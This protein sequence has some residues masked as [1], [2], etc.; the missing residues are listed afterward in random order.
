MRASI[1]TGP[2]ECMRQPLLRVPAIPL[3]CAALIFG[4]LGAGCGE[5][6][7]PPKEVAR[8]VKILEIGAEGAARTLEY[9]GQVEASLHADLGF[10]VPGRIIELPVEE[11]QAVKEGEVLARLDP[12]DF[13]A[14]LD[15][16]RAQV[17]Q[18]KTEYERAKTLFEKD[19][20]PQ[21]DVDRARR[22]LDVMEAKLR[23]AEKAVEDAVLR[24]P[25]DGVVARKLVKDFRNVQA[26]EPVLVLQDDSSLQIVANVPERDWVY[27]RRNV[28]LEERERRLHPTVTVSN[29]PDREFPARLREAATTADPTTRTYA[30]TLYFEVPDDVT[31]MPGM[32]ASV[33][34]DVPGAV[35]GSALAIPASAVVDEGGG[36]PHVWR[37]DPDTMTVSRADVELGELSGDQIEIL[38]GLSPGDQIAVS[39]VSQLREG[40]AVRR[41]GE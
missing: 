20:A 11:G 32:T 6:P 14:D 29:Y 13:Q 18:M 21:Q 15:A 35:T 31:V 34:L 1:S 25:F 40:M 22:N 3:V 39:G 19:V 26:K 23:T 2:E 41:F 27:A 12:R 7:P 10:E 33:R 36:P 30:L 37:V 9:P 16:Q 17:R 24:A 8:P 38:G 5:E 28:P 4:A